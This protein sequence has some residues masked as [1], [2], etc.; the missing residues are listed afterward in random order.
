MAV[1]DGPLERLTQA[2]RDLHRDAGKPGLRR[3]STAIRGRDDLK[4]TVSH[5]TVSAILHGGSLPRWLKLESVVRQLAEWSVRKPDPDAEVR[6]F[7]AIWLEAVDG[8]P[9]APITPSP[10][11]PDVV[12]AVDNPATS[13]DTASS[14]VIW[15]A[16]ARNAAFVGRQALLSEMRRLLESEPR[17]P[18]VIRGIGGVGKTQLAGEFANRAA[19]DYDV[20]WWVPAAEQGQARA[21]LASLAERLDLPRRADL[22]QTA[23]ATVDALEESRL[24]WLLIFDNADDPVALAEMLPP[25]GD[26]VITTRGLGWSQTGNVL[27]VDVFDRR[28]SIEL[29]LQRGRGIS[30]AE[31]DLL[32]TRLG[33]LPL[34]LEQVAAVQSETGMSVTEYLRLFGE[35]MSDL[36]GTQPQDGHASS[37]TAFVMVAVQALRERTPAAVQLFELFAFLGSE[38]VPVSLFRLGREANIKSSLGRAL[39]QFDFIERIVGQLVRYGVARLEPRGERIQ[40]HRLIRSVVHEQ[41][42][43]AHAEEVRLTTHRLL[44]A[45]NP[46]DP[47]DPRTWSLHAEIGPHLVASD[48]VHSDDLSV[49]TAVV[50]QIRYLERRGDYEESRRL[51]ELAVAAWSRPPDAEAPGPGDDLTFRAIRETANALR[52]LGRY[53]DAR[54]MTQAAFDRLRSDPHYGEGHRRTLDLAGALGIYLRITGAYAEA[55]E[56]DQNVVS[57]RAQVSED[58][59]ATL[60]AMGNL[61]VSLRMNGKF[62]EAYSLDLRTRDGFTLELGA[63]HPRALL[64]A[65]NLTKDL[66]GLGKFR[67]SLELIESVLPRQIQ[68][69]GDNHEYVLCSR[70]MRVLGLS[71]TGKHREAV[72]LAKEN[73]RSADSFL[74]PTNENTLLSMITHANTLRRAKDLVGA[75]A[76]ADEAVDRCRTAL[77]RTHPMVLAAAANT[78]AINRLSGA[79]DEA[80]WSDQLTE[81]ELVAAVGEKHPYTLAARNGLAVDLALR[82]DLDAALALAR[83]LVDSAGD[84]LEADHPNR[85]AFQANLGLLMIETGQSDEGGRLRAEALARLT[86]QGI[87][88]AKDEF[89]EC[90]IEP[91]ES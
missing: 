62:S 87:S 82:H 83:V 80:Y 12:P 21:A 1:A 44:G 16:P 55:L 58:S 81:R 60:G 74:G 23:L 69:H 70:R 77:G 7:H 39:Y 31:A 38:P 67:E 5:E 90:E 86:T 32:A 64:A 20:V 6:R 84:V 59:P 41:L 8:R 28:E 63:D 40:V 48:A 54:Q 42:E 52:A 73:R 61:A 43:A 10:P 50:D 18:L 26:V 75:K 9:S 68:L 57:L 29:L 2:I 15:N 3:I 71:R 14:T 35:H 88:V 46:G 13:S 53:E 49:R 30:Q 27:E 56:V 91:P 85:L 45:A 17:Q 19:A 78:A 65:A 51:G 33:D 22:H 24:R 66:Y 36:L 37:V 47:N 11:A 4:D 89:V 76:L 79:R 72:R 34:A 25:G